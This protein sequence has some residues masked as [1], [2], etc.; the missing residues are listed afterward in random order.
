MDKRLENGFFIKK[1]F[2]IIQ[3][4][5]DIDRYK[6]N[7]EVR[8]KIRNKLKLEEED[9]LLGSI[10]T[11]NYQ[12][13]HDFL[14]EI[15]KELKKD[16]RFKMVL[17]GDGELREDIEEKI[18]RNNMQDKVILIG[19]VDNVSEYLQA[20]D[21]FLLSSRFEGIP[22]VL[23]EA[24]VSGTK[25]IVSNCVSREA[26]ITQSVMFLDLNKKLWIDRI[27]SIDIK[28]EENVEFDKE[29]N[30]NNNTQKLLG[31]YKRIN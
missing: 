8:R 1:K 5:I 2:E 6:C 23:I 19:N 30:L 31:I 15:M 3:N 4:G 21:L 28:K 13:N 7:L 16:N 9:I 18:K 10:G 27:C 29:Y 24:Q 12:K 11:F 26:D 25:C 20:I 22:Y 14:L 17:I